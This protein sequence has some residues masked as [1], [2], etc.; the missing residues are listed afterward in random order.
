MGLQPRHQRL[1]EMVQHLS[2]PQRQR[3]SVLCMGAWGGG[4]ESV[5]GAW[6]HGGMGGDMQG[7]AGGIAV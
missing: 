5:A 6:G 3:P 7:V 2:K 4:H 1:H